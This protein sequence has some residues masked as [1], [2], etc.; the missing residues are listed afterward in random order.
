MLPSKQQYCHKIV[1]KQHKINLNNRQVLS[2]Y[3]DSQ[4][5]TDFFITE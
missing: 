3:Q 2:G 4:L 5:V 1:Y